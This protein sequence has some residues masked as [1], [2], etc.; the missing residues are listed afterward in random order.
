MLDTKELK[1][2]VSILSTRR[3]ALLKSL[4]DVSLDPNL[5]TEHQTQIKTLDLAMQKLV[6][7]H[8]RSHTP[9]PAPAAPA[10]AP[11]PKPSKPRKTVAFK[12]AYVL[13]AED[14]PESL[15]LLKG[16]LEDFGI[17]KIDTAADG[18]DALVALQKC[19]P[20]Y[21][22]V[23]CDWDMPVMSGLEVRKRVKQLHALQDTPFIMV[24]AISDIARIRE[25]ASQGFTDYI[26]K[27]VDMDILERKVKAALG[28]EG[29]E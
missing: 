18:K 5:R 21:D 11:P 9:P 6:T 24:T 10:A 12:D 7:G 3:A 16:I 25:A 15:L 23:L 20:P 14:N 8:Q 13:I 1:L 22:L 26:V 27:P 17:K 29:Q 19:S 4:E 28:L 2:V